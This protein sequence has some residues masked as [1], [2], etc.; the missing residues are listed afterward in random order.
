M[1]SVLET[2]QL[3]VKLNNI[4]CI[5]IPVGA[6]ILVFPELRY[7]RNFLPFLFFT[8]FEGTGRMLVCVWK[9]IC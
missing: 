2:T 3:R 6:L 4:I 7:L 9:K 8:R 5:N 1:K